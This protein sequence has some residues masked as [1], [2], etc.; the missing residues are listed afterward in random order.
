MAFADGGGFPN[1][2]NHRL[3]FDSIELSFGGRPLLR[4][5]YM[6]WETGTITGLPRRN[7][8]INHL[9]YVNAL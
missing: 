9:G 5:I 3:E 2:M 4:N 7:K 8:T 1:A 6:C